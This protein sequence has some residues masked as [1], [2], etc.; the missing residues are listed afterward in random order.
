MSASKKRYIAPVIFFIVIGGF[1]LKLILDAIAGLGD[2]TVMNIPG[3]TMT[4]AITVLLV[5]SIP[6]LIAEYYLLAIPIA[7]LF[8]V[9]NRT[10]KAASYEMNIMNIGKEFDGKYMIRRAAVPA[11]FSVAS[12]AMLIDIISGYVI[13][14]STEGYLFS[15]QVP[16]ALM[17]ALLFTPIALLLFMPTWVLNDTGIVTHL[18]ETKLRMRMSP[19]TQ[20][21]GRWISSIFGGYALIAFPIAMF[22]SHIYAPYI[23]PF[24]LT[25]A[26][27]E[28]L[29]TDPV[30]SLFGS[31]L[32]IVGLPIFVMAF[33]V[34]VVAV[35][36]I[37][38]S[39]VRTQMGKIATRLGA[40]TVKK[41][42][43]KK[44]T[45]LTGD[46]ILTEQSGLEL[47]STAK[48]ISLA[49]KKE[50]KEKEIV[51]TQK[52]LAK[53]RAEAKKKR[54]KKK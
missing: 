12:S 35:N 8:L 49:K 16:L 36:E 42:V 7:A 51:S 43:I 32:L 46:G 13:G 54:D 25:G 24:L 47:V 21:V 3:F 26:W 9:A 19:D 48:S 33:I 34:P 27:P 50:E 40:T 39:R 14:I 5:A 41:E 11:L 37:S 28:T 53:K 6:I 22:T 1:A 18:K 44:T 4:D 10:I 2:S 23:A 52:S 29:I 17:G 45:R 30:G 15:E 38:Q 31:L 20:G